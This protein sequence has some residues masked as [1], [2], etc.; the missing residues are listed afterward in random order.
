M[1]SLDN[2]RSSSILLRKPLGYT[3]QDVCCSFGGQRKDVSRALNNVSASMCRWQVE[4][5]N[6]NALCTL[7]IIPRGSHRRDCSLWNNF[8]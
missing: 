3:A 8:P 1:H 4:A 5:E 7:Q 2:D 6:V